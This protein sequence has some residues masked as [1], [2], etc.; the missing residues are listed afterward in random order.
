MAI[1]RRPGLD[2]RSPGCVKPLAMPRVRSRCP[3][4]DRTSAP[5]LRNSQCETASIHGFRKAAGMLEDRR[6]RTDLFAVVPRFCPGFEPPDWSI[7]TTC[8]AT[9]RSSN[10]SEATSPGEIPGPARGRPSTPV[11]VILRMLVVMRLYSPEPR[12]G[13]APPQ[14]QPH[15]P[16]QKTPV[17]HHEL[18]LPTP[19]VDEATGRRAY[20]CTDTPASVAD[21]H[22]TVAERF[23]PEIAFR[24]C[25]RVV[26]AGQRQVRLLGRTS[27]VPRLPVDVH[28]DPMMSRRQLKAALATP[29]GFDVIRPSPDRQGTDP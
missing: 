21:I 11:E 22:G 18:T 16:L 12:A 17:S 25:K 4:R 2:G 1:R 7:S 3:A 29:A 5:G 9:T 10:S 13:R 27:G 6:D 28:A 23:S 19:L 14:G 26:G 15:P 24:E 20:F 8:S